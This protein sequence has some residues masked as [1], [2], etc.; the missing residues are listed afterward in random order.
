MWRLHA[1]Q[2]MSRQEWWKL[3]RE[4]EDLDCYEKLLTLL[5][6][7]FHAEAE[8]RR[9]LYQRK[10]PRPA[11]DKAIARATPMGL[12]D[13]ARFARIYV[14]EKVR[15]GKTSERRM[16]A[17]LRRRGVDSTLIAAAIDE[18][19]QAFAPDAVLEQ[20]L[21]L[22]K[23]RQRT[24][25]REEDPQKRKQKILRFLAARGYAH[26]ICYQVIDAMRDDAPGADKRRQPPFPG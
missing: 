2:A 18:Q 26:G 25:D 9:K 8:L 20:A 21:R 19:S 4:A 14:E 24:W 16:M 22:A 17:D 13:D 7:R 1:G 11:I 23:Q 15:G 5:D 12:I 6:Q 10:F 3:L